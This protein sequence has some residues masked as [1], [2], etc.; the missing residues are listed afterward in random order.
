MKFYF[1]TR[2]NFQLKFP[3]VRVTTVH[4]HL[5]K[6]DSNKTPHKSFAYLGDHVTKFLISI[7]ASSHIRLK[8]S[9]WA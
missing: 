1:L 2:R 3:S 7:D 6:R 9:R 8:P 4:I 5:Q